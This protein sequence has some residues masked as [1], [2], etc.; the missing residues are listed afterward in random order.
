MLIRK[1]DASRSSWGARPL[2][3][4]AACYKPLRLEELP[5]VMRVRFAL[6]L[7]LALWATFQSAAF[8]SFGDPGGG[9]AATTL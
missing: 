4:A 6:A 1:P 9:N 7:A 3:L 5:V 8:A 2:S